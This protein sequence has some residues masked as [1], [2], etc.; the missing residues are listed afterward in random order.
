MVVITPRWDSDSR[1]RP[2]RDALDATM[3]YGAHGK[4]AEKWLAKLDE[5]DKNE[6]PA[7]T[8]TSTADVPTPA[9]QS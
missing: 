3:N 4:F 9:P 1:L 5:E 6:V 7:P 2:G 8:S